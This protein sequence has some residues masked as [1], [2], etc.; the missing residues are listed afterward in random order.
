VSWII[1]QCRPRIIAGLC[2]CMYSE[3]V[4]FSSGHTLANQAFL[5]QGH[6]IEP[7]QRWVRC[8][9]LCNAFL[10]LLGL[11]GLFSKTVSPRIVEAYFCCTSLLGLFLRVSHGQL[12]AFYLY[13]LAF[14]GMRL[15]PLMTT[16]FVGMFGTILHNSICNTF[17]PS[18]SPKF[19]FA[20]VLLLPLIARACQSELRRSFDMQQ[21]LVVQSKASAKL[22]STVCDAACWLAAD[23]FTILESDSRL[24]EIFGC[25]AHG[26]NFTCYL[27]KEEM[28]RFSSAKA[29]AGQRQ[30]HD[31]VV[32]LPSTLIG[33]SGE[34][35]QVDLFIE[36]VRG[37]LGIVEEQKLPGFL[38]GIRVA[39]LVQAGLATEECDLEVPA[40]LLPWN[41]QVA[42]VSDDVASPDAETASLPETLCSVQQPHPIL[43][44]CTRDD[45]YRGLLFGTGEASLPTMETLL[46]RDTVLATLELICDH[47]IGGVLVC[48]AEAKAFQQVF[49][50][51][52]PNAPCARS[53]DQGYMTD[54]LRGVHV[55]EAR[56]QASF[57]EFTR[58][59]QNDRWPEDH[60]H[61]LARGRPKDGA[62]LLSTDGFRVKC[63]AKL[64]GLAAPAR[65]EG[66]GTKH[67]A[68]L[69]C[70]W[71][72]PG[73]SVFV[74]SDSG[75]LHFVQKQEDTLHV[76]QVEKL[77]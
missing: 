56:F 59:A 46:A 3:L 69:A 40:A 54:Y 48:I 18:L 61:E 38:V 36:D 15:L 7:V 74:K 13:P 16:V 65:W 41:R 53:S 2:F 35:H 52:V 67:E 31:A 34:R 6:P 9:A 50:T 27:P 64:L 55:S 28:E 58:H 11:V 24:D 22:F 32:L 5:A 12:T 17:V 4:L 23:G 66:V 77:R 70:A 75:S 43:H 39:A 14:A 26:T 72:I 20:H 73:V 51:R 42:L 19:M 62:F 21:R 1:E 47:A 29:S 68:A 57:R 30:M 60:P 44:T 8:M 71:M 49:G 45:F 33:A 10:E 76:Y 37:E 25:R 63:S